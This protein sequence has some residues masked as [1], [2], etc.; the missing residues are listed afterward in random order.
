[1]SGEKIR[2]LSVSKID[3]AVLCPRAFKYQYV[4]KVPQTSSGYMLA[5]R[6]V[7]GVIEM[8]ME[9][10]I[11]GK[12]LPSAKDLDDFYTPHWESQI[13]EEEEKESFLGWDWDEPAD[14]VK[15][16]CRA[17]VKMARE[18]ILPTLRPKF[19]EHEIKPI[20]DSGDAGTFMV[21]GY[22][23]LIE[24]TGSYLDWKTVSKVSERAKKMGLQMMGYSRPIYEMT[25]QEVTPCRKIFLVRGPRPRWEIV[26]FEVTPRHREHFADVAANV[27]RMCQANA[28]PPVTETWRCS[29]KF[30][31]FYGPCM[32]ELQ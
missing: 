32:G 19:V 22:I 30:C 14:T 12:G 2:H 25:K 11:A 29:P 9:K 27:W 8:A 16:Q 7:H 5:G 26:D 20:Y 4:D 17:L 18:E 31:A 28:F 10:V 15:A 6:A 13:R 23:D 3:M 24:E 1:M 21:W